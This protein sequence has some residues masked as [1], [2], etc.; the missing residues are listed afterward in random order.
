MDDQDIE[1]AKNLLERNIYLE[2][3]ELTNFGFELA[4]YEAISTHREWRDSV[5]KLRAVTREQVIE[6]AKTYLTLPRST[7]LEYLP[8]GA[9]PRSAS[10]ES[11]MAF[12]EQRLPNAVKEAELIA[13]PAAT[14]DRKTRR[15]NP[16]GLPL[17]A[18]GQAEISSA[19]VES[20]LTEYKLLRG[21]EVM[22][23]ES[24]ALPLI[25]IGVFFPGG[26]LF[27]GRNN[28]G[29]TELMLRTSAKGALK[30]SRAPILSVFE[31]N[32]SRIETR[33]EADFFGY[34]LTGLKAG[35]EKNLDALFEA[36]QQPQF[37]EPQIEKE[38][39]AAQG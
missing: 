11:L 28:N 16:F 5:R 18:V 19:W 38:K 17:A 22:V 7:V 39:S 23:K 13:G 36:I 1:R 25:S 8:K 12:L 37:E 21:P 35:F 27:E 30:M 29:I 34:V 14:P 31:R 9:K 26:R 32:G 4:R 24:R 20:P 3:E 6:V 2:R 15:V 33:A 10:A